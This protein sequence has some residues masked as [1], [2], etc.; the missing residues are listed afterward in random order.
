[1]AHL[2]FIGLGNMGDGTVNKKPAMSTTAGEQCERRLRC[3]T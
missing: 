1:M 3:I 2:G